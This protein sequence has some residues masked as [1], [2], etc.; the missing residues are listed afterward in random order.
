[1]R[2]P[3]LLTMVGLALVSISCSLF[4]PAA[5]RLAPPTAAAVQVEPTNAESTPTLPVLVE[6]TLEEIIPTIAENTP[7]V[8]SPTTAP[9]QSDTPSGLAVYEESFDRANDHWDDAFVLTSQAAGREPFFKITVDAGVM[10]FAIQDKETYIYRFFK[11]GIPG[12]SSVQV[13]Y[14]IRGAMNNG[15]AAVCKADAEMTS[16]YEARLISG[17]SRYN[18]YRYDQKLKGEGKNPYVLLAK[19]VLSVKEFS[20]ATGNLITFTCTDNELKLDINTGKKVIS[21]AID[22]ALTGTTVGIG[23]MSYDLLPVVIDFK[24]VTI[25]SEKK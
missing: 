2:R 23:A 4:S 18:F 19:G 11:T 5:A 13:L 6:P 24:T 7:I 16:W 14:E 22:E 10:R 21:L 15:I 3:L 17:E 25:Q 9:P 1:M 20:P 8:E 12:S